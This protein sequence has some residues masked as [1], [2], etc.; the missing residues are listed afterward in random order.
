MLLF[1]HDTE[2]RAP[3]VASGHAVPAAE[4]GSLCGLLLGRARRTPDAPAYR[5]W[6][7]LAGRWVAYT[8]AQT[9]A[10]VGRWQRALEREGLSPGD[11]VAILMANRPEWVHFDLAALGL[12][13]VTVPLYPNDRPDSVR[14]MLED[15]GARLLLV[16]T[17][18][19][20]A[21]LAP[22][23]D[24]LARL[25]RVLVLEPMPDRA[26]EGAMAVAD[27]LGDD[28]GGPP[29]D[30]VTTPHSLA[31]IVYTSGTTGPAKGVMLTHRNLLWNAEAALARV[32]ARPSDRFLSFLPLSH[33]LER[34][35]G[36]YLPLMAGACVSYA[37][38]IPQLAEDMQTVRPT[39]LIAVP[40][41][42]ER[43]HARV[44]DKLDRGSPMARR[45]FE[46][47]VDLGWQRFLYRQGRGPWSPGLLLAPVLDRL[48]GAKIRA[49]LGGRLRVAVCGGAPLSPEIARTFIGLGVPL[50]QGYGLTET[51]PVISVNTLEDNRPEGVGL[52]LPDV[53]AR[54]DHHDELLVRSPGVMRGYWGQPQA[55]AAVLDRLG[56]LHTGDQ[57][58]IARGHI[59]I[60]GRLKET[61]VLSTGE[62]VPPTDIESAIVG[63]SLFA[64]VLLIGEARPFLS[65]LAVLEPDGYGRLAAAEGLPADVAEGRSDPRLEGLLL[66]RIQARLADFPGYATIRRV[67]VVERPW[68]IEDGLMTP[69][70]KLKRARILEHY[71]GELDRLYAGHR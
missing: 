2:A 62:K 15:S 27:W 38:S 66:R 24:T 50:I 36:Y 10:E 43:V 17:G 46:R 14:H 3:R 6:D 64:Q 61:L 9:L 22:I 1:Q 49:R 18:A 20:R 37:R 23:A 39:V 12:G 29:E 63:D 4:A 54:I 55:T 16:E 41:I 25:Q 26:G 47:A 7:P 31:T 32:P 8:W 13:L 59:F 35:A 45:L 30:R 28:R 51:S 56:W 57:A 68:T 48:V 60:T 71:A 65:L 42:F 70:M 67:A 5:R 58:R 34:T 19:M 52:P 40:R 11:R 69:T 33:T 53:E 44:R 21:D